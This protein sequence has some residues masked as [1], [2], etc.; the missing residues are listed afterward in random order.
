MFTDYGSTTQADGTATHH[1]TLYRAA[2]R[3]AGLRR[4]HGAVVVG[5]GRRTA[6]EPPTDPNMQQATVNLF[7]DMGVAAVRR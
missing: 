2:E 3:R 6:P 7:A 4:R 5:P 1:L